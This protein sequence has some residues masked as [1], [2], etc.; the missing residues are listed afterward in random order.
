MLGA[1]SMLLLAG[2]S[3]PPLDPGT[4]IPTEGPA[5]E[6]PIQGIAT[7]GDGA[8]Y[9]AGQGVVYRL[10]PGE[11]W[12]ALGRYTPTIDYDLFDGIQVSGDFPLAFL[13]KTRVELNQAL[14]PHL[15]LD[16]ERPE[17]MNIMDIVLSVFES[18]T[19]EPDP[20]PES[21]YAVHR[22]AWAKD[23]AWL[24]TGGG[25]FKAT[26]AGVKGPLVNHAPI[27]D[28]IESQR[29]VLVLTP[30]GVRQLKDG[31]AEPWRQFITQSL[32]RVDGRAAFIAEG[33]S[34]WDDGQVGPRKISPPTGIPRRIASGGTLLF[35]ATD[36]AV[37]RRQGEAWTLCGRL[38]ELPQRLV[39]NDE[40]LLAVGEQA[41]YATNM[42]CSRW[43][44]H[45]APW[46]TEMRFYDA[47]LSR[48]GVWG[49]TGEGV[50]LLGPRDHDLMTATAV[51]GFQRQLRR[52]PSWPEAH[53]AARKTMIL[54]RKSNG[55]GNRPIWRLLLP[56]LTLNF[57]AWPGR[58]EREPTFLGGTPQVV[59]GDNLY[60]QID[61]LWTVPI[62]SLTQLF[63]GADQTASN[64]DGGPASEA[65]PSDTAS[66]EVLDDSMLDGELTTGEGEVL[67]LVESD[68]EAGDVVEVNGR[69]IAANDRT[70]LRKDRYSL[71][72]KL[73]R[74]YR[75][76]LRLMYR[77][78]LNQKNVDPRDLLRLQA[79]DA[80]IDAY[81]GGAWSRALQSAR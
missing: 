57:V 13:E 61:A 29:E 73:R 4:W 48:A 66:S 30:T 27:L 80:R 49:A 77:L 2:L 71:Y 59:T 76:R 50:F 26:A 6:K 25:I 65:A 37:Y 74:L 78:F 18:Y 35:V 24:A 81:T 42:D 69:D 23:G 31:R 56:R 20:A 46:L 33:T 72:L 70:R 14:V 11:K 15:G 51:E 28:V 64:V 44:A 12:T 62:G 40:V 67:L 5:G 47:A 45:Q 53:A 9:A 43:T 10:S 60:Y 54:D 1:L 79:L 32:A 3:A 38:P 21:V 36:L 17:D 34:W 16:D 75:E 41:I 52:L 8:V 7:G 63:A 22:L 68:V 58:I 55:F 19:T 39:S